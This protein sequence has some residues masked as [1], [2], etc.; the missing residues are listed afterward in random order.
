MKDGIHGFSSLR[1]LQHSNL[2]GVFISVMHRDA[3]I[4]EKPCIDPGQLN[5]V[6]KIVLHIMQKYAEVC[7]RYCTSDSCRSA[8]FAVLFFQCQVM[9]GRSCD[10]CI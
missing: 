4:V 1:C 10:F 6:R 5:V 8:P 2:D 7:K 9:S 3:C